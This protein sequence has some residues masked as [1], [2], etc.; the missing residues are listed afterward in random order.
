MKYLLPVR[1]FSGIWLVVTL[2]LVFGVA[3]GSAQRMRP[4][5]LPDGPMV[6]DTAGNVRI[7]VVIVT[8]ELEHPQGLAFL[9]DGGMLVTEQPGRLRLIRDGVLNPRPI[10]GVPMVSRD[11]R[12]AGLWDIAL[13]PQFE[14]NQ[15]IYLTY[16]K[17][18]ED[19]ATP[20]LA[21]GRFDGTA[22]TGVRDVFVSDAKDAGI[23]PGDGAAMARILLGP[24]GML[25]MTTGGA[26]RSGTT[27]PLAQDPSSHAGKMLRLRDDGSAP[28]DNPFVGRAGYKPEIYSLG[29][30]NQLG[31]AF[32]PETGELWAS[33]NAPQ[34]GDEVNVIRAGRNYGWPMVSYGR[35][36]AGPWVTDR[37]WQEGMEQP[38]VVWWPSVAPGGMLFYTGDRFPAWKGNLF[39]ASLGNGSMVPGGRLERFVLNDKQEEVDREY[40]LAQ[41]RQRIRDVR[42]GPDGLL[43]VL[44]AGCRATCED[45]GAL[46]RIE[47]A[48]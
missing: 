3:A 38:V 46:L 26:I 30:R 22:L 45:N 20:V 44:T 32:H 23:I 15:L 28:D 39:V 35:E 47:P 41:L 19:G 2:A 40:L 10:S 33:E 48:E 14:D 13:H 21:Q 11:H 17:P 31:L 7:R 9:P 27:G 6:F 4:D 29:H 18:S 24:D 42:Q 16:S 5:P 34:G 8:R 12:V 37:P 25:Y 43:Y 1:P 36:Y